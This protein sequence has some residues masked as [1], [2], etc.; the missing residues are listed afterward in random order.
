MR[1]PSIN[2]SFARLVAAYTVVLST[3]STFVNAGLCE[4]NAGIC[5]L[6]TGGYTDHDGNTRPFWAFVPMGEY[7]CPSEGCPLYV[8]IDGTAQAPYQIKPDQ[9]YM[10]EMLKRGFVAVNVGYDASTFDYIA[11]ASVYVM[12][13]PCI[14]Y[15]LELILFIHLQPLLL[16][17]Q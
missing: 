3:K 5:E 4:D 17:Y 9:F 15:V 11:G 12:F 13:I 10:L 14:Q 16:Y 8:W 2:S 7:A 1:I 6:V